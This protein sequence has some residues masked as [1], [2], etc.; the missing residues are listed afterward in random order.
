MQISPK[1]LALIKGFEGLEL[2][3]YICPAG[4][5]TVGYGSTGPHVHEGMAITEAEAEALLLKDL[6][7]FEK[8]VNRQV[9]VP[10]TQGAYDA[11]VSFAFNCGEGALAESTLL[12]R[13]NT[14]EDPNTVAKTELPRWTNGGLEG[15]VRRRNAEVKLFCSD[16]S[17]TGGTTSGGDA[18]PKTIDL[19]CMV[20]TLL[21]KR[22]VASAELADNEKTPV[23]LGKTY[24]GCKVL[25][26]E[27]AH[28]H[29]ELPG[30][31]GQWWIYPP[32]WDNGTG[33]PPGQGPT[34]P[35]DTKA[36]FRV[37][38]VQGN[39]LVG[40][41]HQD[42]KD[43][44]SDGWRECQSSSIAM[45]L[46]WLGIG[47]LTNDQQYVALVKKHGD[48]TER[49]PHFA[50]MK[51]LGYSGATWHTGLS[52]AEIKAEIL[53]AKPVAVGSLHH[54]PASAPTG[55]GHFVVITGFTDS[56]WLVQDPYGSQDLVNGGFAD[57]C[58][59]AGKD[60][61]YSFKN[62]NPRIFVEGDGTCWGWTFS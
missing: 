57:D 2:T 38:L 20:P 17:T 13:L 51:D 62:F 3:A 25:G 8:A 26:T 55:G 24:K 60:Q 22:P 37:E 61:L 58:M 45:C 34:G 44:A 28:H 33:G 54:G 5:L 42:Q 21:K 40:F 59:G 6:V 11:L 7:R 4:V 9:W 41:K 15:L 19:H 43:N 50:A 16:G 56:A 32:H 53:K 27:N 12:R 31:A 52:I 30:G 36:P 18:A 1:G 29:I 23:E 39:R 47:N 48:T 49:E 10:M 35:G 46:M 14:G